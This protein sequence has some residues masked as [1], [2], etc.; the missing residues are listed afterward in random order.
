MFFWGVL[1]S[2]KDQIRFICLSAVLNMTGLS[3]TSCYTIADFPKPIKIKGARAAVQGGARW[4]ESEV[5][6]WMR[7]R[8]QQ[9]NQQTRGAA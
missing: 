2:N 5:Q 8:I 1:M 3:K 4:V 6:E 9:R 7:S